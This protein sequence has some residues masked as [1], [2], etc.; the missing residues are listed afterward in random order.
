[1]AQA[2]AKPDRRDPGELAKKV[3]TYAALILLTLMFVAPLLWMLSTS[4][5]PNPETTSLPLSW[6]PKDF[7]TEGYSTIFNSSSQSPALI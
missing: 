4:L 6:I 3:L 7:S 1:M 5:K 2:T